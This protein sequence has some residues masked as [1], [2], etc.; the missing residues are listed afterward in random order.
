[1]TVG[2]KHIKFWNQ[3][4]GGFTSNRGLFGTLSK[5]ENV[6]CI[7]FGNNADVCYTGIGNGNI[8]Y[9]LNQKLAKKIEA[10]NGPVFSIL[11]LEN[12]AGFVTGGKDGTV[13]LWDDKFSKKIQTYNVN[14]KSL[15]KSRKG[16]I[17]QDNPTIK[18]ICLAFAHKKIIIGTISGEIIEID[19]DGAMDILSQV[20]IKTS[21]KFLKFKKIINSRVTLK[22]SYGVLLVIHLSK[23]Y[24]QLVMIRLFVCGI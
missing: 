15:E 20:G 22:V 18:A 21:F 1:M 13:I 14:K 10:H 6:L 5:V 23:K 3:V 4:G 7:T 19:K 16:I 12:W 24:A 17:S 11:A 2:V 8:Y 9:W